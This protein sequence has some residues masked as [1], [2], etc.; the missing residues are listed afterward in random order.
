PCKPGLPARDQHRFGHQDLYVTPFETFEHEIRKQLDGMLGGAGFDADRDILG[1]TVNRWPHGYAYEYS[2][3][4]DEQWKPG[5]SPC[6]IARA[7]FGRIAIANSDAGA[8]AYANVAMDQA[9]RAVSEL[10]SV[11]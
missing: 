11:M 8:S 5:E 10:F 3:L 6:E 4:W 2:S 9:H 1:I 7:R